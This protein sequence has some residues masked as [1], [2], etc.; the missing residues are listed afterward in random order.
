M[1][2]TALQVRHVS[3]S[4]GAHSVVSDVS[5]SVA[6]GEV[7]TLIGP[8]GCGKSTLLRIVA[9]LEPMESGQILI[10]GRDMTGVPAERRNIGFVFQDSAL[11]GHLRVA[12][13][14]AFGLRHLSRK[15]RS[16]RVDE[17]LGL[18]QLTDLARRY[19]HQLSGGEQ[20][21]VALARALAS[22]PKVVLLDEPFASL[23]GV[24]R[25][26]LGHQVVRILRATGTAAVLVTHDRHEALSLGDRLAVMNNGRI[27]QCSA[28]ETVYAQPASDFVAT[29]LAD[30][31]FVT[32]ADGSRVVARPHQVRLLPG[33]DDVITDVEFVG[34][35]YRYTVRRP[36][37]T[38]VMAD[39][40]VAEKFA[41]GD[42]CSVSVLDGS[43]RLPR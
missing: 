1:S 16:A 11:F 24:L 31:S 2:S 29:F 22:Q 39:H 33:G 9:G 4:Y 36:D 32:E 37:G 21:R 35:A 26:G 8:S 42:P 23:D 18:V 17:M 5:L 34:A 3:H 25:E 28:P 40:D 14:V 20:Q 30:T 27:E 13:N 19:P 6:E 7:L 38:S 15:Q 41:V 10:A 43:A 12:D